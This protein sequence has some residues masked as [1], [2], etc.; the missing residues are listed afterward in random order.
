METRKIVLSGALDSLSL[1]HT[2]E[3]ERAEK[4][5]KTLAFVFHLHGSFCSQSSSFMSIDS[6]QGVPS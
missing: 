3:S 6:V 1:S 2:G 5:P 4:G